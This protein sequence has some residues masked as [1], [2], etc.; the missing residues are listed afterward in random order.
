MKKITRRDFVKGSI[1][2]G[3]ALTLPFS[4]ARGANDDLRVAVVGFNGQGGGHISKF[5]NT[6]GVRVVALCDVDEKVLYSKVEE[7]KKR[8][9]KVDAYID[10]RKMLEDKSIDIV[11]IA[12]PYHQHVSVAA[13]SV[14]AGKDVYVEKPLSHTMLKD[15]YC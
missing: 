7:F 6:P 13:H 3:I 14:V 1:A 10:Y 12:T 5:R 2:G 15:D 9:E 11:S 8:N 4:R